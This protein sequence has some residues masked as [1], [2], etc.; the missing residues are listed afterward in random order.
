MSR[1]IISPANGNSPKIAAS[2]EIS[3]KHALEMDNLETLIPAKTR[4]YIT[5]VGTH[6]GVEMA[7]ACQRLVDLGLIAVPHIA[8]RRLN[9]RLD[10]ETRIKRYADAGV[11][12]VLVIG[13][14]PERAVGDI[15]STMEVLATGMLD[16][17]GIT[18]IAVAGHPEGSPDFTD[19]VAFAAL[20]LKKQFAERSDADFRI[21]TQFGFD[22]L[23]FINWAENLSEYGIDL[24]VHLGVAGPAKIT[25]LLKYAAMCGVGNSINFLKKR[26]SSLTT[27][28]TSHSPE[29]M[30]GPIENHVMS[31]K[32]TAIHG[33]HAFPFGG[34]AKTAEWLRQ[35]GSWEFPA[36][37]F[38][39][40]NEA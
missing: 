35:R 8:A 11:Y 16:A 25:T 1:T 33:I 21:V 30:V 36:P 7:Q 4:A 5:D 2:I 3:P 34:M 12:D 15:G 20:R 17:N 31:A 6:D 24:P 10:L 13:G 23:G 26:A 40:A 18:Q 14:S 29:A 9:N 38:Q 39:I 37:H 19:E 22:P 28:L 27:L 32:K